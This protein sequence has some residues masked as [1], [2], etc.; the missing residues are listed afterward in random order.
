[1][2]EKTVH[3]A[4]YLYRYYDPLTGRW[5][6]RDLI[7]EM[8][9]VNL[10]GFAENQSIYRTDNLGLDSKWWTDGA[11]SN[12]TWL[13]EGT[14]HN[15][16]VVI[17]KSG[18]LNSEYRITTRAVGAL[19][20]VGGTMEATAGAAGIL[21]PEPTGLTKVG[22][23]ILFVH[24]ADVASTGLRVLITGEYDS[25]MTHKAVS[26][27]AQAV[28]VEPHNAEMIATGAELALGAKAA[29]TPLNCCPKTVLV[30]ASNIK[31]TTVSRWGSELQPNNWVMQGEPTLW[32]YLWSGKWQPGMGN[33]FAAPWNVKSYVVPSSSL[34]CPTG[35]GI[36]GWLKLLVPAKQ[37]I[38]T[39]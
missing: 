33:Q 9:G 14:K 23:F 15:A 29:V 6:S 34:T 38:Y 30:Q 19:Q 32:N 27:A 8:G 4:D 5:P 11:R 7:E 2:A 17:E 10:Y 20:V 31:V 26:Q 24:G 18:E 3:V 16:T 1:L 36:D 37:R 25:T 28:G 13:W 35:P 39:P 22:G 21:T 12:A